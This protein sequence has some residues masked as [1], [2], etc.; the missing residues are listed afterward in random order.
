MICSSH[1]LWF[2]PSNMIFASSS[3]TLSFDFALS[4][5]LSIFGDL[6]LSPCSLF[7][8]FNPAK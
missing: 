3:L 5:L 4:L 1:F 2:P 6:W 7:Y 8:S